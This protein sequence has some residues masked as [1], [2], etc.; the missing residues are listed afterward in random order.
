MALP[1]ERRNSI[2]SA[3]ATATTSA[4]QVGDVPMSRLAPTPATATWPMPSPISDMPFCT[5]NTPINGAV[6]PTITPATSA[7]CM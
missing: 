3:A 4:V 7:S 5:M 2:S 6:A 1:R